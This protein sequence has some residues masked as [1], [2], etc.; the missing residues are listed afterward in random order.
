[1]IIPSQLFKIPKKILFLQ[2]PFCE[3]N[4]KRSKSFLNKFYNFTNERFK[5]IIRWKTHNLKSLFSLKDKDL[6]PACKVYKGICSCESTYVSETKRNV[7]VRYLE[8]NHPTGK[9]KPS[10]YLHQN[11]SHVFT[12]LA[13]RSAPKSDRTRKNLEAFYIALMRSNLNEQCNST[14]L[15]LLEMIL[16]SSIFQ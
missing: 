15:T 14:V 10:K 11:I 5:L 3:A 2:L 7:E 9:S 4:E 6:H 13:I 16:P 1:M 12:W 8:H